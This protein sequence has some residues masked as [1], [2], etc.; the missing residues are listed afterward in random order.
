M[1]SCPTS[2]R[3]RTS[4]CRGSVSE[5]LSGKQQQVGRRLGV[6]DVAAVDDLRLLRQIERRDRDRRLLGP[7]RGRDRPLE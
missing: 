7:T 5:L 6:L 3:R 2:S 4:T 1:R